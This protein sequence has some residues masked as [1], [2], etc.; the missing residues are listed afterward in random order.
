[1][2][3]S[4]VEGATG[5]PTPGTLK[6][7]LAELQ[8]QQQQLGT[9]LDFPVRVY[10]GAADFAGLGGDSGTP[11]NVAPRKHL[12]FLFHPPLP[13]YAAACNSPGIGSNLV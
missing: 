10:F 4:G 7:S 1:M 13:S 11:P 8:L 3:E 2:Q 9:V 6:Q 5:L 12:M